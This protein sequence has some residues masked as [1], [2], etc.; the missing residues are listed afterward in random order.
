MKKIVF[1]IALTAVC[2]VALFAQAKEANSGATKAAKHAAKVARFEAEQ[3]AAAETPAA[4]VQAAPKSLRPSLTEI[5]QKA[6]A[7]TALFVARYNLDAKQ[8]AKIKEIQF[9]MTEKIA[10]QMDGKGNADAADIALIK[11]SCVENMAALMTTA[12]RK[13]LVADL[14]AGMY[15]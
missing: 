7:A 5:Q 1:S 14:Q 12:Q 9:A 3:K 6:D 10:S 4:V 13:K 15:N 2:S 8:A 11:T